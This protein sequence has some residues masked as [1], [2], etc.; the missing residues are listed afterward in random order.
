MHGFVTRP[1]Y[2]IYHHERFQSIALNGCLFVCEA[3][4]SQREEQELKDICEKE[5][6]K[7]MSKI[8]NINGRADSCVYEYNP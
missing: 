6:R 7:N 8:C 5:Q 2:E 4:G 1:Q 3:S